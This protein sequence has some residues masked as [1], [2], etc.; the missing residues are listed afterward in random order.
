[1]DVPSFLVSGDARVGEGCPVK[2]SAPAP[3]RDL[4]LQSQE[5]RGAGEGSLVMQKLGIWSPQD[6][7]F[8]GPALFFPPTAIHLS[9]LF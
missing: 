9:G 1:M 3:C 7:G 4:V 2:L 8:S 6:L 5:D